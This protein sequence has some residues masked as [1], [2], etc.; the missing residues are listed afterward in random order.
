MLELGRTMTPEEMAILLCI[1][2]DELKKLGDDKELPDQSDERWETMRRFY[3][4]WFPDFGWSRSLSLLRR[5]PSTAASV[6]LT[7]DTYLPAVNK[8]EIRRSRRWDPIL[9]A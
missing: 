7:D 4:D 1:P 2:L 9:Q 6:I 3:S 5:P 8:T